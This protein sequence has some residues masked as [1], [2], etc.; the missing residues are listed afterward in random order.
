MGGVAKGASSRLEV[1]SLSQVPKKLTQTELDSIEDE[2][3][4][5][6]INPDSCISVIKKYWDNVGGAIARVKEALQQ[7]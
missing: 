1:N 4:R 2:L 7:G 3:K 5:L 6:K